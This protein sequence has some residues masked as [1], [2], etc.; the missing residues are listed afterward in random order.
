MKEFPQKFRLD[1]LLKLNRLNKRILDLLIDNLVKFHSTAQTS[2]T[3]SDYGKP[4]IM[5]SKIREN[6]LTIS[7]LGK[8]DGSFEKKLNLFVRNN[9]DLFYQRRKDH[10]IRDIHGDLYLKNIFYVKGKFYMYDRIEFNDSLRYADIAED[11]AHLAMDIHYHKRE[12]LQVYFIRNYINKSKDTNIIRIIYFMMCFK[13]C[14]R[15]KVSL[16][17]SAHCTDKNQKMK[18]IKEAKDHLCLANK[19]LTMF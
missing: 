17:S 12:D 9:N 1:N 10:R 7:K 3:I 11:V 5:E 16:F 13:A 18:H 2:A 6:F 8:V 15:A 19:Y 4:Q 14:V